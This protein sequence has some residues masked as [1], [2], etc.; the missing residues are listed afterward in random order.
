MNVNGTRVL[1]VPG[2]A[3]KADGRVGPRVGQV[4]NLHVSSLNITRRLAP[5]PARK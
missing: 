1:E 4:M 2:N 3:L 5:V